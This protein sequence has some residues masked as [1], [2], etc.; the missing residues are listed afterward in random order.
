MRGARENQQGESSREETFK[1][2]LVPGAGTEAAAARTAGAP[3]GEEVRRGAQTGAE[4][5]LGQPGVPGRG[6]ESP[7]RH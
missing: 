5:P 1:K 4:G 6:A 7:E 2:V 3:T